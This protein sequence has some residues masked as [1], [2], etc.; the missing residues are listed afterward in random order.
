MLHEVYGTITKK[1]L[2]DKA[3]RVKE[4]ERRGYEYLQ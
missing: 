3:N 1:S 2:L 4:N